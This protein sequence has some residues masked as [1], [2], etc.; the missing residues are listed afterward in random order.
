MIGRVT[1]VESAG[2]DLFMVGEVL[3][4]AAD[5]L[6]SQMKPKDGANVG[7][8]MVENKGGAEV[9]DDCYEDGDPTG[10]AWEQENNL[11]RYEGPPLPPAKEYAMLEDCPECKDGKLIPKSSGVKCDSCSY[12]FCH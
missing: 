2:G 4:G 11:P 3:A 9:V 8:N 6:R 10:E 7:Y 5:W 1:G 12:W